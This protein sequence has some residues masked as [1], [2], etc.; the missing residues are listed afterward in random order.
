M[1]ELTEEQYR[2]IGC[3]AQEQMYGVKQNPSNRSTLEVGRA[4]YAACYPLIVEE[5]LREPSYEEWSRA[6]ICPH[7]DTF[8]K[9]NARVFAN[10]R[11]EMLEQPQLEDRVKVQ[12]WIHD[13]Q[14]WIV[15]VDGLNRSNT[16][17][18]KDRKDAE[19]FRLGYIET[20]RQEEAD[21]AKGGH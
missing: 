8:R 9:V 6:V 10:R 20:L 2:K 17:G 21:R 1:K 15:L 19:I 14:R 13:S 18:F 7:A 12:P 11:A 5:A 3:V 4:A 16:G